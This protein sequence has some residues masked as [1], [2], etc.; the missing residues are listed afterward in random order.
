MS[1]TEPE[2]HAHTHRKSF[3]ESPLIR[4]LGALL[5]GGGA[6]G[7]GTNYVNSGE[8]VSAQTAATEAR[9][10]RTEMRKRHDA[11]V[12]E[13]RKEHAEHQAQCREFVQQCSKLCTAHPP[14]TN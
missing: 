7:V 4:L 6:S 11:A 8:V 1:K 13:L 12:A 3:T 10:E 14:N 5:L 9:A 2:T